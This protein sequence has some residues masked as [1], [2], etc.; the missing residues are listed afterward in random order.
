MLKNYLRV[1]FRTL[2]KHKT[3]SAINLIGLAVSLAVCL[4]LI[5]FIRSQQRYDRF[6]AKADRIYR[7]ITGM[8][9][10]F[11]GVIGLA[12]SPAPMAE[13]LR[14][15]HP[16]IE[17]TARLRKLGAKATYENTTFAFSGFYAEPGFFDLFDFPLV[18][19]EARAALEAPFSIVLTE[20]LAQQFFGA[21]D[22]IGKVLR[23]DDGDAYVVSGV[24]RDPGTASHLQFEAL[25]SFATL[26][27]F[28][29]REPGSL[30]LYDWQY[31]SSIYTYLLLREEASRSALHDELTAQQRR[32]DSKIPNE[33][34]Q[35]VQSFDLQALTD[36]NLGR[37]LSN[38]VGEIMPGIMV[39][40]LAVLASIITLIACFNYV[41]LS[42]ARS[43]KRAKEVGIRKVAGAE[44]RQLVAQFLGESVLM[45]LLAMA[46][47]CVLLLDLV[48]IFNSLGF[49]REAKAQITAE[50]FRDP[51]LYVYF[52]GFSVFVGVLA[53]LYPALSLSSFLP[54]KVLKGFSQIRGF[55]ALN[56][57]R[58]LIVLQFA[59]ALIFIIV[60]SFIYRQVDFMLAADYG[61]NRDHLVFVEL[62]GVSYPLFR[63]E[64]I[65]HPSI[66][67]VAASSAVLVGGQTWQRGKTAGMEENRLIGVIN[68]DEHFIGDLGL[69]IAAGRAFD[70]AF[71][72]EPQNV[73]LSETAVRDLGL[74][75][76]AAAI[77][78]VVTFE[79]D[80][81]LTVVGVVKEFYFRPLQNSNRPL[82]LRYDPNRFRYAAV[83][84][85]GEQLP[86][87]LGHLRTT[88]EK[89]EHAPPLQHVFFDDHLESEYAAMRDATS[90]LGL[91]AGFA[92]LI[93]CLGL[94]GMVIYAV[95][96]RTKEIGV[97]K[98]LG[99]DV[100]SLLMLLSQNSLKLLAVAVLVALP[101]CLLLINVMQQNFAQRAPLQIGLF[102]W[103]VLGLLALAALTIGSQTVKAALANPV[104]SLR[105]E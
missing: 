38:E 53:G 45:T 33:F 18:A 29:T 86:A 13:A 91:S 57:R 88:W 44:K 87:M 94:L 32:Y 9:D 8:S 49:I 34:G 74:Q 24:M 65:N 85:H 40:I 41:S 62:Q 43:L 79:E 26:E 46:I 75:N 37:E 28:E 1:A 102:L 42:I 52:L 6:H 80:E 98:V 36:I 82:A 12:T 58:S 71:A 95:E 47:A 19:G 70:P 3:F 17:A 104:E 72:A 54:A 66:A 105:Y 15:N 25:V 103:P 56:L 61:F 27:V 4:L 96:T 31:F 16:E 81:P 99:A 59:L 64:I 92:I 5:T 22:P 14:A 100:P 7:V 68:I 50:V 35:T 20:K 78:A 69:T 21:A 67:S 77:D 10:P 101:L 84:F 97:R 89:F 48:P 55:S 76:P 39:Y 73:I 93:A 2:W 11:I 60:T 23:R 83:R 90:I 30:S 51:W 63:Q